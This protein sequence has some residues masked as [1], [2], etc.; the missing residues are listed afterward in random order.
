MMNNTLPQILLLNPPS[1]NDPQSESILVE[2]V[3]MFH[4]RAAWP[5]VLLNILLA[6]ILLGIWWQPQ[7]SQWLWFAAISA[8]ALRNIANHHRYQRARSQAKIN[9]TY[10]YRSFALGTVANGMAWGAGGVL[11]YVPSMPLHSA[12]I[13][14]LICGIAAG[15]SASQSSIWPSVVWFVC[16]AILPTA[17]HAFFLGGGINIIVGALLLFYLVYILVVGRVN[18]NTLI[19]A[20]RL[21]LENEQLLHDIARSE[22]YFRAMVEN[23]PDLLTVIDHGGRLVF[24]SP[25]MEN[26][27]GHPVGSMHGKSSLQLIHPDDHPLAKAAMSQAFGQG[28]ARAELRICN[29]QGGWQLFDCVG[30]R[31]QVNEQ[32][33]VVFNARDITEQRAMEDALRRARDHAEQASRIKSQFLATVSH[34]IRT[35][36]HAILGMA[37]MLRQTPLNARQHNYV[38]TFHTAGDH[39]LNLINDI[40]DYSRLEAGGLI[41][42]QLDFDLYQLLEEI[43]ALLR[44]QASAKGLRLHLLIDKDVTAH[45]RG[46]P[47]RLKQILMNLI[48][49]AIKFTP[50]GDV[51][52]TLGQSGGEQ[53]NFAVRDTGIGIPADK[54]D[55]IFKPFIQ[56]DTGNTREQGGTGL[57]LSICRH[58]VEAMGG[59]IQVH[60]IPGGGSRFD[61]RVNLPCCLAEDIAPTRIPPAE[62]TNSIRSGRLLIVDD[63]EMNQRIMRA[64]LQDCGCQISYAN[65]G[66]EAISQFQQQAPELIFMDMQMPGMDGASATREIRHWEAEHALAPCP[67]IALSASAMEEDSDNA[68]AAGCTEFHPKPLSQATLFSLLQKYL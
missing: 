22:Q 29:S 66:L 13:L 43:L 50:R 25:T 47:Q 18:H 19:D 49:N 6:A 5:L 16:A 58:L 61:F 30:R 55:S 1:R 11:F 2:L 44:P 10:W 45:R 60:S 54:L 24:E 34:E 17:V 42:A 51:E 33:A 4:Q 68:I 53:L 12:V 37:E 57:G 8:V 32:T 3:E 67:I 21:R 35:P 56:V 52:L 59:T 62:R 31:L 7:T 23:L 26:I 63:S 27:L 15:I 46:D 28:S 36:L 41:L 38:E 65:N 40:L 9:H 64:F 39:L 14:M 48:G 20:V